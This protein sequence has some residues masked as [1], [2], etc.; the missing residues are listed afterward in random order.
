[1]GFESHLE[2]VMKHITHSAAL[3]LVLFSPA[4]YATDYQPRDC[5]ALIQQRSDVCHAWRLLAAVPLNEAVELC[6][7]G[8]HLTQAV[9]QACGPLRN[10]FTKARNVVYLW[11]CGLVFL[12]RQRSWTS[13]CRMGVTRSHA[14]SV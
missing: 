10:V 5:H 7:H 1:M 14:G 13:H 4:Q 11:K 3:P 8:Q 12:W 6:R 9:L 2:E